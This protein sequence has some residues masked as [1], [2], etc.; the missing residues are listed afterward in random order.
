MR[1]KNPACLTD[2]NI[3]RA[4]LADYLPGNKLKQNLLLNA[5]DNDVGYVLR[6]G[7][8]ATLSALNCISQLESD[9]GITKD[10]A[11]WSV[12]TWCYLLGLDTVAN[13]LIVLQPANQGTVSPAPSPILPRGKEYM[14]GL[15][16]YRAGIDFPAG[17]ISVQ[18][19]KTPNYSIHYGVGKN[20]SRVRT[21][22]DFVDKI[23]VEIEE[24]QYLKLL[25]YEGDAK[26]TFIVKSI[27]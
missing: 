3:L 24:G 7:S 12:Q 21:E 5:F 19:T 1:T 22:Q 20:P 27:N 9:Y 18:C 13:A 15:G 11:F 26:Y 6:K 16:I 4:A 10:A 14:I 17:E 23:Y 2:R 25:S 8:D